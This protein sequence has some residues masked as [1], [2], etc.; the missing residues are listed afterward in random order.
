MKEQHKSSRELTVSSS[1]SSSPVFVLTRVTLLMDAKPLYLHTRPC[2]RSMQEG[3]NQFM[4][5]WTWCPMQ[6]PYT[7]TSNTQVHA[8]GASHV[9]SC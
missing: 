1:F 2:K 3:M 5:V 9:P 6:G 7:C 4:L 8:K